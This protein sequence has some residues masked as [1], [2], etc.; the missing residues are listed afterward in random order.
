MP[1]TTQTTEEAAKGNAA[2]LI[3][4]LCATIHVPTW[5]DYKLPGEEV[6][7]LTRLKSL[8]LEISKYDTILTMHLLNLQDI[9]AMDHSD[10]EQLADQATK[11]KAYVSIVNNIIKRGYAHAVAFCHEAPK[12]MY[13]PNILSALTEME[14]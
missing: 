11:F 8:A 9:G 4:T 3:P 10:V 13:H 5:R 12:L 2:R 1:N 14:V 7:V 6:A